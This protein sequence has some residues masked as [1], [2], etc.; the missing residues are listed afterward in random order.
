MNMDL[1]RT[2]QGGMDTIKGGTTSVH[3]KNCS[4]INPQ[5]VN[6]PN[7]FFMIWEVLVSHLL[8]L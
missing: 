6:C 7:S 4:C 3:P 1:G 5:N 2:T 8:H